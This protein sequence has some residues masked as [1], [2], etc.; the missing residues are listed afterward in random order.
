MML[1]HVA[2]REPS[3]NRQAEGVR[4]EVLQELF[5]CRVR[6]LVIHFLA[7]RDQVFISRRF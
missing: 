3:S 2:I 7:A 6:H 5:N 1:Q 4:N